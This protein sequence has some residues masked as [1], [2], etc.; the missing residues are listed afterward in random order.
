MFADAISRLRTLGL[1]QDNENDDVPITTEDIIENII[2]V[3]STN[4]VPRTPTYN[5]WKLNLDVLRKEQ[6]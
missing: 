6:Q 5:T 3:H 2:E 4:V 1:Y